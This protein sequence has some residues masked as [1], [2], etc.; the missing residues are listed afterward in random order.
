MAFSLLLALK[1]QLQVC[2]L[3]QP[4]LELALEVI[5]LL[6]ILVNL[7]YLRDVARQVRV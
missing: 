6:L 2:R 3:D 5:L 4:H 1:E 7:L